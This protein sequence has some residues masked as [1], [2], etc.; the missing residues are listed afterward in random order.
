MNWFSKVRI[1]LESR[2]VTYK[3][4]MRTD[5]GNNVRILRTNRK[6]RSV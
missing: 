6:R 1:K 5:F 3:F 2:H 4:D